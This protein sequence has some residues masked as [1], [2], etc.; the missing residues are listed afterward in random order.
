MRLP[1]V[2]SATAVL[3]LFSGTV[4]GDSVN[5][6]E[7]VE[8]APV[9]VS[10]SAATP[11]SKAPTPVA[12]KAT[13]DPVPAESAAARPAPQAETA[14]CV[15][16][17]EPPAKLEPTVVRASEAPASPLT[18]AN[19]PYTAPVVATPR[20][21]TY[22]PVPGRFSRQVIS[23]YYVNRVS[24]QLPA[25]IKVITRKDWYAKDIVVTYLA[26]PYTNWRGVTPDALAFRHT[27]T[28]MEI[29]PSGTKYVPTEIIVTVPSPVEVIVR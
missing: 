28:T 8:V 19:S 27:G 20:N 11:A 26:N 15:V 2:F 10:S 29:I 14:D 9:Q 1:L 3:G 7:P 13:K 17:D 16:V 24:V 21:V 23:A 6:P 18:Q 22:Q 12:P 25:G 4:F 5:P